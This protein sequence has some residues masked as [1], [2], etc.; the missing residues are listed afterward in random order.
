MTPYE[1]LLLETIPVRLPPPPKALDGPTAR[2]MAEH[3]DESCE[4]IALPAGRTA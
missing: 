4:V 2:W 1:S 3:D